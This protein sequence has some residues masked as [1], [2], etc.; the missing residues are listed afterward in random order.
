MI[1]CPCCRFRTLHE[2]GGFEICPVCYWEDD[3]QD[4]IDADKVRGGPNNLLSLSEARENFATI[5]ASDLLFIGEVR[6]PLPEE[7][8]GCTEGMATMKTRQALKVRMVAFFIAAAMLIL[9]LP[10]FW[11]FSLPLSRWLGAGALVCTVAG[12]HSF[13]RLRAYDRNNRFPPNPAG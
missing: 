2:T 10:L 11:R 1:P 8:T 12:V 5:G 13:I 3:G 9:D 6:P 7:L 4:D